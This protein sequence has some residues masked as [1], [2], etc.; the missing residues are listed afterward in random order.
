MV[1]KTNKDTVKCIKDF[2]SSLP[3]KVALDNN[4][5]VTPTQMYVLFKE[6]ELYNVSHEY[7]T[8]EEDKNYFRYVASKLRY[9]VLGKKNVY[10]K[11][12]TRKTPTNLERTFNFYEFF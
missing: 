1:D 12:I 8:S 9:D 10:E 4:L 2:Q 7:K 5:D 6:G 11:F 3:T